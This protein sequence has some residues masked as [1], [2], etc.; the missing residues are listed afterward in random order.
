MTLMDAYILAAFGIK[1]V[2]FAFHSAQVSTAS[3][4]TNNNDPFFC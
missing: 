3:D 4:F 2:A 1:L